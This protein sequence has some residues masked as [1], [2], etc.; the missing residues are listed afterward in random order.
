MP[1]P[2]LGRIGTSVEGRPIE[3]FVRRS[4]RTETNIIF[5]GFHGNEPKSVY[6]ARRLIELLAADSTTGSNLA[7][8]VVPMVNPDGCFRRKRRNANGVDINRNFPTE[9]W[10]RGSPRSRMFGGEFP[11][12]EPETRTVVKLVE[13]VRPSRIIAIHS[14]DRGR[15]CN[16]YDGPGRALAEAMS[17][18][19]GYP[20]KNS[21]GYP[22]PGSFGTWAGVERGIPT[23]TL[24]LPSRH[25]PQRCWGDNMMS[26]L[27]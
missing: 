19:N 10:E 14:I 1:D 7:W 3:S 13:R 8:V 20:V 2:R 27:R 15:E 18:V 23:I 24:E 5:G 17:R 16:N 25:S 9:N 6:V 22:T 12:S 21:I 4:L 26:L 11:A